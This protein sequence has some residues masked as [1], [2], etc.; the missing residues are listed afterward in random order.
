MRMPHLLRQINM[1]ISGR[2]NA[3]DE[4]TCASDCVVVCMCV[5]YVVIQRRNLRKWKEPAPT[6]AAAAAVVVALIVANTVWDATTWL[7]MSRPGFALADATAGTTLLMPRA[8][9]CSYGVVKGRCVN[10]YKN[11]IR[12]LHLCIYVDVCLQSL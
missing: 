4:Y 5:Y 9:Y 3:T 8:H 10:T 11:F 2:V 1:Y 12:L 6:A 7:A